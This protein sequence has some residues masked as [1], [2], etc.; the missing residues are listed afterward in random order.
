MADEAVMTRLADHAIAIE[1]KVM[2]EFMHI[3]ESKE[4]EAVYGYAAVKYA[5]DMR[6]VK[7][8]LISDKL[9]RSFDPAKRE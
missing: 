9:Y 7:T 4:D 3:A 2:D 8:L 5:A 1:Q 6:V